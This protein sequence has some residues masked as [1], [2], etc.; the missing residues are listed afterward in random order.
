MEPTLE[1]QDRDVLDVRRQ[2]VALV[3]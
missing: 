2:L 1:S 3:R